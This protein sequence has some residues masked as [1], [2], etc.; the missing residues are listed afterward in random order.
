MLILTEITRLISDGWS[1][2]GT[3]DRPGGGTS[4]QGFVSVL[5]TTPYRPPHHLRN[6]QIFVEGM[7]YFLLGTFMSIL[8]FMNAK[9]L[10]SDSKMLLLVRYIAELMF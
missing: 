1:V 10:H 9:K 7:K 3:S 5:F 4:K 2:Q 8:I 6:T